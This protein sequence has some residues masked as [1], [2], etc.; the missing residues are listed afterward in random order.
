VSTIHP[1]SRDDS[2]QYA[3]RFVNSARVVRI[4]GTLRNEIERIES[5]QNSLMEANVRRLASINQKKFK[6]N[7]RRLALLKEVA[8]DCDTMC[9]QPLCPVCSEDFSSGELL[10]ELPC[11]HIFHGP[12]VMPWLEMKDSCPNCRLELTP[13]IPTMEA[14]TSQSEEML[15]QHLA[16]FGVVFSVDKPK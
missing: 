2:D 5:I 16:E 7:K 1:H 4:L 15:R 9:S 13:P 10:S 12:C 8:F 11:K 14:L 6:L 3:R